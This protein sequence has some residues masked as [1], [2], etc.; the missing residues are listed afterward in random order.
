MTYVLRFEFK[1]VPDI[2]YERQFVSFDLNNNSA[3]FV[4]IQAKHDND[5]STFFFK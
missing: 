1:V 2:Q 4:D 5:L 3:K